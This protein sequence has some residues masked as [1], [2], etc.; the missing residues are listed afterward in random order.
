MPIL[1][2]KSKR[3]DY[4]LVGVSMPSTFHNFMSLYSIAKKT[5]KS[6]I[7]AGL[8]EEWCKEAKNYKSEAQLI[9]IIVKNINAK[10]SAEKLTNKRKNFDFY[11][12]RLTLEL[13]KKGITENQIKLILEK[14]K[15]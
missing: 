9:N 3:D 5:S 1:E 13:S 8:I 14:L 12:E 10:W 6:A 2:I 7:L 4:R 15:P 11:K